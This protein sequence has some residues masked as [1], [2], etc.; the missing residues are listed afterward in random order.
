MGPREKEHVSALWIEHT[1]A[2]PPKG[3]S[4]YLVH[5]MVVETDL[6]SDLS[7]EAG[8]DDLEDE[9]RATYDHH[10]DLRYV[11]PGHYTK[12]ETKLKPR[13]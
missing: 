4:S 5:V 11:P 6:V 9:L 7:V 12:P 1:V 8:L 2:R 13:R 3:Q 10:S